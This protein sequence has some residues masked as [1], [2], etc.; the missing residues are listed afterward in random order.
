MSFEINTRIG[1]RTYGRGS[2]L[3]IAE[4]GVNHEG[5]IDLAVQ[6][7][8]E[9]ISNGISA[10][11]FQTYK[12]EKI[13]ALNSPAYWDTKFEKTKSQRELFK[14][15]DNFSIKDYEAL[16]KYAHENKI[17]FMTTAFDL[18][19]LEGIDNL[20]DIHKVSSSDITNIPFLKAVGLKRKPV[21]LSN[22]ASS[23]DELKEAIKILK[24]AGAP[25][26]L[27]LHCILNYPTKNKDAHLSQILKLRETFDGSFIGY[28]DHT[29]ADQNLTSLL[30][31][32]AF[33]AVVLEKHYTHN[34]TLIGND[35][36]HAFDKA[37]GKDLMKN[38]SLIGELIGDPRE[39]NLLNQSSAIKN[40]RRGIYA[41]RKI[42][43]GDTIREED[44]IAL[45]PVQGVP[46]SEWESVVGSI[47]VKDIQKEDPIREGDF[48]L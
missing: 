35:H 37:D 13:A 11:K 44:L 8:D 18:E 16:S 33:G 22:G 31:A 23:L 6:M 41:A 21:I 24:T 40:A 14:K 43:K 7:I 28:S 29:V 2:P 46:A 26:V 36:Y 9:C 30:L 42:T 1:A 4:I 17:L 3:M 12:A 32:H 10:V 38:L 25:A 15:Y 19:S 48:K 45:R 27:P 20:V 34:K 47:A 39:F 5:S